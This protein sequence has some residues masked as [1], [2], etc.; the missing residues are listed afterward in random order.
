MGAYLQDLVSG[1]VVVHLGVLAVHGLERLDAGG[2]LLLEYQQ[3]LLTCLMTACDLGVTPGGHGWGWGWASHL[4]AQAQ[5]QTSGVDPSPLMCMHDRITFMRSAVAVT[6]AA[7]WVAAP[8]CSLMAWRPLE[9]SRRP[10]TRPSVVDR[11]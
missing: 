5:R 8:A 11:E 4:T 7:S 10:S 6:A 3:P 9:A 2:L 1:E